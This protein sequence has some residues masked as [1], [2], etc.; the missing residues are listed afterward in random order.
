MR[1]GE[2][3]LLD[4]GQPHRLPARFAADAVRI[5][6]ADIHAVLGWEVKPEGLCRGAVC[7]PH[8]SEPLLM[9]E[10]GVDLAAVARLLSRPLALDLDEGAAYLGT[11]A[12][13][14][15]AQLA[16][17]EAPN[18]TLPDLA[19]RL[20]SLTDYRGKKVLLVAYA[21]W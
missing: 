6:A 20:H 19:G 14:R 9:T 2:L 11:A 7:V 1:D 17:L 12:S 3:T 5:R 13:D 16:T 18:F 21:S 10:D 8:R 4:D 15:A